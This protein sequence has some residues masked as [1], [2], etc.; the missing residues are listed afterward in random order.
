MVE[1]DF[2]SGKYYECCNY[3]SVFSKDS[4]DKNWYA[5]IL[6]ITEE[7]Y[8]K[9]SI[10]KAMCELGLFKKCSYG[11]KCRKYAVHNDVYCVDHVKKGE[12]LK[13]QEKLIEK[14]TEALDTTLTALQDAI[15]EGSS[16]L[17]KNDFADELNALNA[18]KEYLEGENK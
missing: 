8:K 6:I 1:V 7:K 4:T 2:N 9:I 15:Y 3:Y 17:L 13:M 16:S 18:G 12:V 11:G 10:G 14:L 5:L